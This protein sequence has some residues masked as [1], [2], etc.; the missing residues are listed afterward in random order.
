LTYDGLWE[1]YKTYSEQKIVL[2]NTNNIKNQKIYNNLLPELNLNLN[3]EKNNNSD[4]NASN[5]ANKE[6]NKKKKNI[7]ITKITP[8]KCCLVKSTHHIKGYIM[9][10]SKKIKFKYSQKD[11]FSRRN[12]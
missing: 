3:S 1:Q 12:E 7:K 10:E 9:C 2:D 6:Q 4:N 8:F 5:T 11:I